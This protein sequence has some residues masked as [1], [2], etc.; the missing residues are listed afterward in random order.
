MSAIYLSTSTSSQAK[1]WSTCKLK[2][3]RRILRLKLSDHAM[4]LKALL[5]VTAIRLGLW[6]LPFRT[7]CVFQ[8]RINLKARTP[9]APPNKQVVS[10]V[11]WAIA[12][13]SRYVPQ[14]TCLTQAIATHTLLR[15]LSQPASIRIG[16]AKGERGNLEAHAWVESD[17]RIIIGQRENLSRYTLLTSGQKDRLL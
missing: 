12:S 7:L 3:L 1:D 17:G 4:L 2:T 9:P 11:T 15:R 14:A 16:V 13:V 8:E 5:C 6:A 10:R